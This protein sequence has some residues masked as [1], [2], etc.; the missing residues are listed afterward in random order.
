MVAAVEGE[1]GLPA[2]RLSA[3]MRAAVALQEAFLVA[4]VLAL[5]VTLASTGPAVGLL[6][7]ALVSPIVVL[8]L[9]FVRYCRM[10]RAW[11]FAGAAVLGAVGVLLRL[12][13]STQPSLEVGGGLPPWVTVVYVGLGSTVALA[14]YEAALELRPRRG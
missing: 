10:G 1:D 4:V 14:S 8:G 5:G 9:V 12:V 7:L 3:T 2:E 6:A 13:V 11:S